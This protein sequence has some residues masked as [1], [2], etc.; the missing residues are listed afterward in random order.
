[1]HIIP[2]LLLLKCY[3]YCIHVTLNTR[4][5]FVQFGVL[6]ILFHSSLYICDYPYVFCTFLTLTQSMT[7]VKNHFYFQASYL[8]KLKLQHLRIQL[9]SKRVHKNCY[10]LL[11]HYRC[12]YLFIYYSSTY[13][14]GNWN[15]TVVLLPML[16]FW[17]DYLFISDCYT[18]SV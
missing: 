2:L 1:M 5:Q 6:C 12:E 16:F 3:C 14:N 8:L 11:L 13:Q 7:F 17:M 18:L 15:Q 9:C 4:H 10:S